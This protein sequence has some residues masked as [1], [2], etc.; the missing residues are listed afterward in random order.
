VTKLS[1]QRCA[2]RTSTTLTSRRD[3]FPAGIYFS[4]A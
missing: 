1:F 3:G 2:L 4:L